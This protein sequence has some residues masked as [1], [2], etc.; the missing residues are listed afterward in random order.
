[1]KVAA[2]FGEKATFMK[3][4]SEVVPGIRAV[5]CFG[6]S[7]GLMSYHIESGGQRLLNWADVSNHHIFSVQQPEWHGAFDDDKEAAVAT[8]KRVLDWAATEHGV[9]RFRASVAP[10]NVASLAL[11]A[12]LGF[13]VVGR[14]IDEVDGEELVLERDDW[15]VE[16]AI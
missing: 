2:P 10:D 8:R 6:H 13:T 7:P 1:M 11:V 15:A 5:E 14:R 9:R 16:P 3:D 12:R 4:G